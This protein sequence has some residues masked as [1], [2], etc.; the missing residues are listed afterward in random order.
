MHRGVSEHS[1]RIAAV[2]AVRTA[3][4]VLAELA[5]ASPVATGC[6]SN[7]SASSSALDS[8]AEGDSVADASMG[9]VVVTPTD[10]GAAGDS[11]TGDATPDAGP[12]A[13]GSPFGSDASSGDSAVVEGGGSDS[14]SAGGAF[15]LGQVP[16]A[17]TSSW[18]TP[19]AANATFT[20]LNWP[21]G[22]Q[23]GVNWSSYSTPI[24]VAA[25]TDPLVLVT[26]PA[27]WGWPANPSFHAP[28]GA[29]GAP[30]TDGEI[31]VIDGTT[32]H[33]LW[34]FSRTTDTTA[35]AQAYARTDVITGTGWGTAS[36]FAAAGIVA[37][38]SSELAGMIVQ[39]ETDRGEIHH[40]IQIGMAA[41]LN[42][43]GFSGDAINGDGPA[44]NGLVQEGDRMAIPLNTAMPTGLSTL[45][46]KVFRALQTY[47]AF[48][49]D[50]TDCCTVNT[51]AQ[52]NGYDQPTMGALNADVA[53]LFPLMQKVN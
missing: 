9:D 21:S 45:G 48:D 20:V 28:S 38:G 42:N 29:T 10:S 12:G 27:S 46:Q 3:L 16:F 7:P 43:S 34:V 8:G 47:G 49:I 39:A 26:C 6:S 23:Y 30:G 2:R 41:T 14:A 13:D 35:V 1:E 18:N 40:A 51:R 15:A 52:Q 33:N 31:L 44:S 25:P 24:Y 50:T 17:P 19:L 11:A 5:L 22:I 53:K 37:A 32:V 4:L 36:P